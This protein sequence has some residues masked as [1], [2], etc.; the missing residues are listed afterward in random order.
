MKQEHKDF[1]ENNIGDYHRLQVKYVR[2]LTPDKLQTYESIYQTYIDEK[3][4]LTKWCSDC[5]YDCVSSVWR[6]Y[7]NLPQEII[8][9]DTTLSISNEDNEI[10]DNV[11]EQEPI[12]QQK[13]RR[14]RPKK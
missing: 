8:Q 14:G 9:A 11:I 3:Y 1:L 6:Y 4:I 13:K 7:L 10:K 12:V 2:N 5:V